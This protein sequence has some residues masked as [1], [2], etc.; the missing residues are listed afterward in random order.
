MLRKLIENLGYTY[1]DVDPQSEEKI[2]RLFKE[3]V[4]YKP[5]SGDEFLYLGLYYDDKKDFEKGE[6][7]YKESARFG[8]SFALN[9][10]GRTYE[11]IYRNDEKT[12]EYYKKAAQL[13]NIRAFYNLGNFYESRN[14]YDNAI[15]YYKEAADRDDAAS[16]NNLAK[17][18]DISHKD[19]GKAKIYYEK[20]V[21]RGILAAMHNLADLYHQTHKD[22]EKAKFYYEKAIQ[23]GCSGSMNNLGYMYQYGFKDIKTAIVYYKMATNHGSTVAYHNLGLLYLSINDFNQAEFHLLQACE[24]GRKDSIE[25][26]ISIYQQQNRP[27]DAFLLAHKYQ[28]LLDP[29]MFIKTISNLTYPISDKNKD[30]IYSILETIKPKESMDLLYIMQDVVSRKVQIL[31]EIAYHYKKYNN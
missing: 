5:E 8:N 1:V 29:T 24:K 26:L 13:G 28:S 18:Y 11:D 20:A 2:I 14:D 15:K 25:K 9:N 4:V 22:Y 23:Q 21:N 6:V 27:E 10:L 19:Y 12:V 16:M 17:L 31:C 3:N 30:E 7:C